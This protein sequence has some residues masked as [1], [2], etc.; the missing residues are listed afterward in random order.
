MILLT[1]MNL[2]IYICNNLILMIFLRRQEIFRKF[3]FLETEVWTCNK[4]PIPR[5]A[6]HLNK[7]VEVTMSTLSQSPS[8]MPSTEACVQS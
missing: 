1:W 3:E 4:Y 5:P 2:Y 7:F 6:S 8:L